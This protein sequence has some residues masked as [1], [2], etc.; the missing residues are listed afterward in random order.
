MD[1]ALSSLAQMTRD[2]GSAMSSATL[3]RRQIWLAQTTLPVDVKKELISMPVQPGSVFHPD[4]QA[5]LVKAQEAVGAREGVK[6]TFKTPR[7]ERRATNTDVHVAGDVRNP[8]WVTHTRITV[9]KV[10]PG[11]SSITGDK[12]RPG[13]GTIRGKIHPSQWQT[14]RP[15]EDAPQGSK[16]P[17][18][19]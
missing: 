19:P 13:L 14:G 1:A 5:L 9:D 2:V 11:L 4:S 17:W 12:V 3:A 7:L 15:N 16:D 6:R 10:R 18:G 8:G